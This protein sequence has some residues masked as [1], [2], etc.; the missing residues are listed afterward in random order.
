MKTKLEILTNRSI[1]ELRKDFNET[2]PFL[3]LEFYKVGNLAPTIRVKEHLP[4]ST[5]LKFAGL[6][7]PGYIEVSDDMT[8]GELEK[9]FLEQYGLVAQ[10]SRNS[11]GVWL[12]TT[13][14]D[15]WSLS[16][17]NDYGREIVQHT[18]RYLPGNGQVPE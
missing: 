1:Q 8:V 3:K 2:Y 10:V 17:Q 18:Q 6:K 4:H 5:L 12:E 7:K 11:G 13:M 14:T 16:K 9:T 15:N